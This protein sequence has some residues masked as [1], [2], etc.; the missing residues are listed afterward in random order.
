M[1]FGMLAA[2]VEFDPARQLDDGLGMMAVL[3]QGVFD[4]LRAA[5]E[6]ATEQAVLLPG[7]PVAVAVAADEDDGGG[8]TARWRFDALHVGIPYEGQ[9]CAAMCFSPDMKSSLTGR[10]IPACLREIV[11]ET[12]S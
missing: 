9:H 2:H 7:N 4:G 5:D 6:Q 3:E 1:P 8:R 12:G 10:R 11:A